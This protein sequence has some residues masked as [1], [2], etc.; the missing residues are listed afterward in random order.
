[1]SD[2]RHDIEGVLATYAHLYD[3]GRV[4]EL[5]D[6]FVLDA[7]FEIRGIDGMPAVMRGRAR[8]V[9]TLAR[10]H[11]GTAA[12]RR[13]IVTNVRIQQHGDRGC[14]VAS[15]LLLG[16]TDRKG[17]HLPATGTYEDRLVKSEGCWRFENRCLGL[18]APL[19]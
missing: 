15:Y 12:Q 7:V 14:R 8:I 6:L 18:D 5:G 4:D 3:H 16:S 9:E 19:S 1:M 10:R 2:V 13:H 11:A 17:S